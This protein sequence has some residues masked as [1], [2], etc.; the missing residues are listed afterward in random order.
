MSCLIDGEVAVCDDTGLTDFD[1]LRRGER[2]K[3]SNPVRVRS[4]GDQWG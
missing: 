4:A 1:L 3:R 2:A